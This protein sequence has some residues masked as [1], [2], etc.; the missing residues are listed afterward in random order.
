VVVQEGTTQRDLL[1]IAMYDI[2][3]VALVQCVNQSVQL[4]EQ[5]EII[6]PLY[7][8]FVNPNKT[9]L[10]IEEEHMSSAT[11]LFPGCTFPTELAHQPSGP[12]CVLEVVQLL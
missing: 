11:D 6:V 12:Y 10:I 4:V 1:A 9:W 8:Y 3:T 5:A 2:S 7:G